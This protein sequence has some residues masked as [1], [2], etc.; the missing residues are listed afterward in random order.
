MTSDKVVPA[1]NPVNEKALDLARQALGQS[2]GFETLRKDDPIIDEY[3]SHISA[4]IAQEFVRE[5]QLKASHNDWAGAINARLN[6][7][8]LGVKLE[9]SDAHASFAGLYADHIES[10]AMKGI[11]PL[12]SHLNSASALSLAARVDSIENERPDWFKL[13]E[14]TRVQNRQHNE[15]YLQKPDWKEQI[16]K[17]SSE[18][19]DGFYTSVPLADMENVSPPILQK[20]V[21]Q[22]WDNYLKNARRPFRTKTLTLDFKPHEAARFLFTV[23]DSNWQETYYVARTRTL[24][25]A[26]TLKL[27]AI[28]E[29]TGAYPHTFNTPVDPFGNGAPLIYLRTSDSY[30]L[31][32]V[33]PGA[34]SR[35]R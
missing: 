25:L 12:V 23:P 24:L 11:F 17:D 21:E 18:E 3:I 7:V 33:G 32:S 22:L 4:R 30:H 28:H 14:K 2:F 20:E 19:H 9:S 5:S 6:A 31:G 10:V 1:T 26:C 29:Q 34:T 35:F 27:Q 15:E 13:L 8:E 16:V